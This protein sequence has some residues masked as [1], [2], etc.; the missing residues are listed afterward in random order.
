MRAAER[1]TASGG[2]ILSPVAAFPLVF[3]VPIV[4]LALCSIATALAVV[5]STRGA[6]SADAIPRGLRET[7]R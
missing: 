7:R 2:E 1:S 4:V 5:P 6:T 3:G